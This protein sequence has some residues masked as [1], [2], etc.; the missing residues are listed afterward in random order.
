MARLIWSAVGDHFYEIGVDR[1]VLYV[2]SAPGV[3]WTG[4]ISVDEAPSG[5]DAKPYYVDGFKYLNIP[6]SEEFEATISAFYRPDEFAVCDGTASIQNGL[7]V[8]QQ[9]RK[10]F[11]LSYRTMVGNDT[12]GNDHAYKIHVV[13]NALATPSNRANNTLGDS[14]DPSAFS[15]SITTMSTIVSGFKPTSHFV[16][17]SRFAP[18]E[19][20]SELEDILY[21]TD[22]ESALLPTPTELI[23]IFA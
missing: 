1:G 9:P 15:W 5:G 19:L 20:L 16:I 22:F 18:T 14:A 8:T 6:A 21:G 17:D 2:G 12:E 11:S 23:A 7:F 13:Y 4:L 10:P 3:A